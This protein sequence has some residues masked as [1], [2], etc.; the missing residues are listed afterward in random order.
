MLQIVIFTVPD[1]CSTVCISTRKY[2][3]L[4]KPSISDSYLHWF[5]SD[6]IVC[7][8]TVK[9]QE[10]W[11]SSVFTLMIHLHCIFSGFT[12]KLLWIYHWVMST[13]CRLIP[14]TVMGCSYNF[15]DTENIVA[16]MEICWLLIVGTACVRLYQYHS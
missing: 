4:E 11:K 13:D 12:V 15:T 1:L 10:K 8:L 16:N 14:G 5:N 2:G 6:L 7:C 9:S 3:A